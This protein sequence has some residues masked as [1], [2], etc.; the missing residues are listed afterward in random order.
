MIP[1]RGAWAAAPV[2]GEVELLEVLRGMLVVAA[3]KR[4]F[5]GVLELTATL[6]RVF[7]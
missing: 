4:I 7:Q 3:T 1:T 2:T 6:R 5:Y